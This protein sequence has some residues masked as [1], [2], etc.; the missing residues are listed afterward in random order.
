MSS[1]PPTAAAER[2]ASLADRVALPV[3]YPDVEST[4]TMNRRAWW[5]VV[6]NFLIP[7]SA[8]VLAGNRRLGRFG[9]ATTIVGWVLVVVTLVFLLTNQSAFIGFI[10]HPVVLVAVQVVVAFYVVLW[11][12]LTLDTLRLTRLVRLGS[13]ARAGVAAVVVV[14]VAVF[15]GGGAFAVTRTASL[16]SGLSVLA[17]TEV[18]PPVDGYYNILLIGADSGEDREG[19]RPDSV[20]VVS[21]EA[22]T[23]QIT[24]Y[25]LPRDL[26]NV[27][28]APSRDAADPL[29]EEG[30]GGGE[31]VTPDEL[32]MRG[33]YPEMYDGQL[34]SIYSEIEFDHPDF[35]PC[36][37]GHGSTPGVEGM[38]DAASGALGIPIQYYVI[39]DMQGFQQ[40]IDALGGVTINVQERLPVGGEWAD[41]ENV[42]PADYW[43]EPGVQVLDGYNALWY[44]RSRYTTSD[45]DRMNRQREVQEAILRQFEPLTV[46]SRFDEIAAAGSEAVRTDIPRDLLPTLIDLAMKGRD[47]D[48][49]KVELTPPTIDPEA[50]DYAYIHSL[51]QQTR[52]QPEP[53]PGTAQ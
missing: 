41:G 42:V 18:R 20:S 46:L 50:P 40:L 33:L 14:L 11:I 16:N 21:I 30:A 12:V 52:V 36:A 28:F 4:P 48:V 39:I 29:A 6:M 34:N 7:G 2:G 45:Y 35:Y 3:R 27:S 26:R 37:T 17:G 24:T 5:L 8:Q 49:V 10:T 25:G 38:L 31:C 1:R 51:V 19:L 13:G 9:L 23:G 47:L 44:A 32:S 53:E 22:A 15:G 43:I